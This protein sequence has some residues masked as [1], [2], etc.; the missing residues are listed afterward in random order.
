[1]RGELV[2]ESLLF[3]KAAYLDAV[4]ATLESAEKLMELL[5]AA[6]GKVEHLEST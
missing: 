3:S 2:G 4:L 6:Q 1:M 5:V